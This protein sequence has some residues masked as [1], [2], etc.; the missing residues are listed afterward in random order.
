MGKQRLAITNLG[1]RLVGPRQIDRWRAVGVERFL[2][3]RG[4]DAPAIPWLQARE[5]RP[6]GRQVVAARLREREERAGDQDTHDVTADVVVV[7]LAAARTKPTG[8]WL[9]GA[10]LERLAQ[11]IALR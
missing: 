3:A 5:A 4:A 2:P 6:R 9:E 7:G 10:W 8:A 11:E 1:G